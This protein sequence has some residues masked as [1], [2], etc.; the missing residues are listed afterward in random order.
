M[1]E[2][3][4]KTDTLNEGREKLNEAIKDAE[5]AKIDSSEA[6]DTANTA[7]SK[8][9]STQTQLDNIVIDGDSSVE[10]AQA[11]VD[12]DGKTY[13][14]LKERLDT[15]HGIVT[16]QL[17]QTD[18]KILHSRLVKRE[19]VRPLLTFI[20][21]DSNVKDYSLFYPVALEKNIPFSMAIVTG[22]IGK[23]PQTINLEQLEEMRNSG[24]AEYISHG[25][26]HVRLSQLTDQEIE[27]ELVDSKKW[28]REHNINTDLFVYPFGD[29]DERVLELTR[30]H[31][32]GAFRTWNYF[33][34]PPIDTFLIQ[35]YHFEDSLNSLKSKIDATIR[36]NG[37]MVIAV[38]TA[39]E[40]FSQSKLRDIIDYA[41][42]KEID[43]VN[44]SEGFNIFG[45]LIDF[46]G[47]D[48]I[49]ADGVPNG[50]FNNNPISTPAS[51]NA[52]IRHFKLGLTIKHYST[53]SANTYNLP[54]AG[55]VAT[56]RP[57]NDA[58]SYQLLQGYQSTSLYYRHWNDDE[59]SDWSSNIYD[60]Y[61]PIYKSENPNAGIRYFEKGITIKHYTSN[62]ASLWDL[63]SAGTLE[64]YRPS[65][66]LFSF[67]RLHHY[68]SLSISYRHW[69]GSDWSSWVDG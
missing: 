64:T 56:Y 36:D 16:S 3:I 14:T 20:L 63:P 52:E 1:A 7:L 26:N 34:Y 31:Y 68:Q 37:W 45:N 49:G 18:N 19:E 23:N 40:T 38:H 24:L 69:N 58:Y 53:N 33:N 28:L 5:K 4:Q 25:V 44:A 11:R 66:D 54:R 59:W 67:Q 6:L 57:K 46:G 60:K 42:N 15:E 12:K 48:T 43:I 8:S 35:R 50:I 21:D 51:P 10:A 2:L 41:K 39:Y 47:Q 65:S 55:I 17:A 29:T 62:G 22:R 30:K 13:G 27:E 61:E 9:E 32:N